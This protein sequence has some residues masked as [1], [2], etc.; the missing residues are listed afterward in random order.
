MSDEE[1]QTNKLSTGF[2]DFKV[3]VVSDAKHPFPS[4]LPALKQ[5]FDTC[6][7]KPDDN[8]VDLKLL[9]WQPN[10]VFVDLDNVS[11]IFAFKLISI[12]GRLGIKVFVQEYEEGSSALYIADGIA[13]VESLNRFVAASEVINGLNVIA[14]RFNEN[15]RRMKLEMQD[16]MLEEVYQDIG[17]E[18]HDEL[19]SLLSSMRLKLDVMHRMVGVDGMKNELLL[20]HLN[21]LDQIVFVAINAVKKITVQLRQSHFGLDLL[22]QF[23]RLVRTLD[24]TVYKQVTS[25]AIKQIDSMDKAKLFQVYR[26][27]Q[28]ALNNVQYH[29]NAR[30]ASVKFDCHQSVL[31][32]EIIDHGI[33]FNVDEVNNKM[34]SFGLAG[35]HE[36]ASRINAKLNLKSAPAEGTHVTLEV[37]T[38]IVSAQVR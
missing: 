3:L 32:V 8:L 30:E 23:D 37:P 21:D 22:A 13:E 10:C 14:L 11:E 17:R 34:S 35:M 31:Q 5:A 28:E 2:L 9:N 7:I 4:L 36:R 38:K 26:I 15:K 16:Q 25:H 29:S 20:M 18:L 1:T 24:I 12:A 33:G 19:G 27:I 6:L